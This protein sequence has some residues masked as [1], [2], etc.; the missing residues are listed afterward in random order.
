LNIL[1]LVESLDRGGLERVVVNLV[2][3]QHQAGHRVQVCCLFHCG[4]LTAEL[5]QLGIGVSS[6]A[7]RP[8]LDFKAVRGIRRQLNTSAIQILH[9]HNAV[10][11]YYGALAALGLDVRLVST[12]HG[13]GFTTA[14]GLKE[15][16]YRLSL[17]RTAAAVTV[18]DAAK[19]HYVQAGVIP[20]GLI[21]VVR[22]GI[23]LVRFD[24]DRARVRSET[25]RYLHIPDDAFVVGTVGRLAAA[26]NHALLI[27]SFALLV[28]RQPRS[29]LL[30]VGEG[31]CRA[32]LMAQVEQYGLNQRVVFTGDR[33]DVP[34]LL[35][36]MDV[37]ALTSTTE[38]YSMALLEAAACSLPAVVTDVGGNAEIVLD[39]VTGI[40]ADPSPQAFANA[41]EQ[42][43]DVQ[44][45]AQ[46]GS[47][48]RL[49]VEE[50]G[51]LSAMVRAY[52]QLY[53]A[54]PR[55]RSACEATT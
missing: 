12:R 2:R 52:E 39:A 46:V 29:T 38:G 41:F 43:A 21:H 40:L 16:L 5:E 42:F 48:A 18:C 26:K 24:M 54:G 19:N 22:N 28:K 13:M 55:T 33:S 17:L 49:R 4:V 32:R 51:S 37:F 53:Q 3:A 30:I 45:V 7:K 35:C 8:G 31:E 44:R 36:A 47:A 10:A 9:T 25:R 23:E 50:R 20:S 15:Q 1:H 11:N 6:A 27:D 14:P 34:A